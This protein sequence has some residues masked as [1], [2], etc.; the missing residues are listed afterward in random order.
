MKKIFFTIY[1][2][3]LIAIVGFSYLFIDPNLIYLKHLYTGFAFQKKLY[4]TLIFIFLLIISFSFYILFIYLYVRGKL[5]KKDLIFLLSVSIFILPFS[6]PAML[7]YD[8]FNYIATAKVAFFYHENPYIIMPI[9]FTHDPLLL[10]MH[11]ANKVALYGPLWILLTGLPYLLGFGSFLL[12]LF[13]FKAFVILFFVG[14]LLIIWKL[15]KNTFSVLLFG[16]NPLVLFETVISGHN[17]IVM[18]FLFLLAI[19]FLRRNKMILSLILLLASILIKYASLAL[20]IPFG[21]LFYSYFKN[22]KISWDKM[23][24]LGAGAMTLVFFL[25]PLR[26]EIYP[27]YFTWILAFITLIPK[28][29][30]LLLIS[31]VF[32]FSLLLRYIPFMLLGTYFGPTPVIKILVTFMPIIFTTFFYILYFLFKKKSLFKIK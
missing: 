24:L 19:F 15:T 13:L 8:I 21:Y 6:Y 3:F 31:I 12:I 1:I 4:T 26:E 17:D 2:L 28:H 22:K 32:S 11:A 9:E 5:F 30:F 23:Y 18:V 29:K 27:W 20:I 16:L 7:S 10:F 25:A 14:T